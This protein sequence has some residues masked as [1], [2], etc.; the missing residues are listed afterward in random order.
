MSS[1]QQN[2]AN[3]FK[4]AAE[5]LNF[6]EL[7]DNLGSK[8][9]EQDFKTRVPRGF[10]QRIAKGNPEDPLLLQVLAANFE[11]KEHSNFIPDPLKE[12]EYNPLPGIL[13]KYNNRLLI[14]TTGACAINCRYCFRRH[15][16]YTDNTN[17]L[18][19][20][21][22]D[23]IKNDDNIFEVILSGGDPLIINDKNLENF[24]QKLECIKHVKILRFHTRVPIVLPERVTPELI[25]IFKASSLKIIMVLHSNHANEL[26]DSVYNACQK[27]TKVCTLLNQ[28]VLLK[29]VNDNPEILANLSKRLLSCDIIPYYLHLLDKT[30]GTAHFE[31]ASSDALDIYAKLQCLLP[32][33]LVPKLVREEA[34]AMHKV[35]QV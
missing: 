16:A 35:M 4:S 17:A 10:A 27:L 24:M 7:P 13:H 23:Y 28:S 5:L 12:E 29:N 32:G 34:G 31:V 9:A 20:Q 1:W 11:L 21:V 19:D 8:L 33:Y 3:G 15:F 14:I 30:A 22:L 18:S 25:K 26:D 2:L 6:L